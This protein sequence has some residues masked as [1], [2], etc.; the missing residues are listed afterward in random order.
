MGLELLFCGNFI[1]ELR[2]IWFSIYPYFVSQLSFDHVKILEKNQYKCT[3]SDK[4]Q[5]VS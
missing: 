4:R 5:Y 3:G 1:L 2:Q